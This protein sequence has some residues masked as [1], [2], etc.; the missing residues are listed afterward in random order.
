MIGLRWLAILPVLGILLGT[1]YVNQVEP[2]IF[3]MPFVLAWIVGWVVA[4]AVLIAIVYAFDPAN[5][6]DDA[7]QV[8]GKR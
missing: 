6:S 3:G 5:A 4:G 7:D 2:L 8:G 1:A